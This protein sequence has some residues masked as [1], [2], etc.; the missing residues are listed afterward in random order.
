MSTD[1]TRNEAYKKAYAFDVT[2][3]H[4][5]CDVI[6]YFCSNQYYLEPELVE[7]HKEKLRELQAQLQGYLNPTAAYEV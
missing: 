4:F 6:D 3:H 1:L 2:T 7:Q 5:M